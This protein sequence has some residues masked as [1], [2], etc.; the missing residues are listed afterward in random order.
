[1]RNSCHVSVLL[2]PRLSLQCA[3][4]TTTERKGAGQLIDLPP[5]K[6]AV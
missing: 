6:H 2:V 3:F 1:M 5:L 4:S